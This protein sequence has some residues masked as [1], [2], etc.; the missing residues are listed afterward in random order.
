MKTI[1]LTITASVCGI[2]AN[3]QQLKISS[4]TTFAN[5]GAVIILLN[6]DIQN[7]GIIAD[8]S[9]KFIFTGS[10]NNIIA[11]TGSSNFNSIEIA[12]SNNAKLSL[13]QNINAAGAVVFNGG[14]ID[15]SN[16]QF[17]LLFPNGLLQGETETSRIT[18]NG[19]GEVFIS[20]TLNAPNNSNP[21]NLGATITSTQN[22][23][24]TT[25]R[26]GH[27]IQINNAQQSIQRYFQ[28]E[29]ANNSNLNANLRF[30][31]FDAELN[32]LTESTLALFKKDAAT[33]WMVIGKDASDI[34][35][36]FVQKN[37]IGSLQKFTLFSSVTAPLPLTLLAFDVKCKD[38][39]VLLQWITTNEVN[40]KQFTIEKSD[41]GIDWKTISVAQAQGNSAEQHVY[42]TSVSAGADFYRLKMEDADTK[43]TYSPVKKTNCSS[44]QKIVMGPNPTQGKL[45]LTANMNTSVSLLITVI[46]MSGRTILSKPWEVKTGLNS[47]SINLSGHPA[48]TYLI[49]V[50]GADINEISKIIKN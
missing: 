30:Q 6:T 4:G 15:L 21:G 41:N 45:I 13:Q 31:Y 40:T 14:L 37:G 23:G 12:K 47:Q 42:S 46:D 10:N 32:N 43:F 50:K 35:T 44:L 36:N 19:S 28:I 22:L 25:I 9:G 38:G 3:A 33:N 26:R 8:G 18:T 24:V 27:Q 2:M 7:D 5:N 48:G 29:P 17:Q 1:L 34:N 49:Q 11:G 16:Q 20:Q 39:N